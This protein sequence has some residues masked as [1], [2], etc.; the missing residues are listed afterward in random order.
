M[1]VYEGGHVRAA[2]WAGIRTEAVAI[3]MGTAV[4]SWRKGIGCAWGSTHR[5]VVAKTGK[6]PR[7]M[8]LA[9]LEEHGLGCTEYSLRWLPIGGFVKMLGQEDADPNDVSTEAG[10]SNVCPNG[11]RMIV[12]SAGGAANTVLAIGLFTARVII[13]RVAGK[14]ALA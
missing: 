11:K 3:G 8:S 10:S 13:G 6:S 12:V 2:K 1:L 4:V 14:T 7:E 9:E 5:Q